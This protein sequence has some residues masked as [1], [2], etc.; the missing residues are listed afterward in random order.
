MRLLVLLLVMA[1]A[2]CATLAAYFYPGAPS[3]VRPHLGWFAVALFLWAEVIITA[4]EAYP[5]IL[6]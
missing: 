5:H 4:A 1:A 2:I 3:P 6:N